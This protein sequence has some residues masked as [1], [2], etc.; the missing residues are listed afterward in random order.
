MKPRFCWHLAY[1]GSLPAHRVP[2][3]HSAITPDPGGCGPLSAPPSSVHGGIQCEKTN[4][5]SAVC[6]RN[7]G[8]SLAVV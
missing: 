3:L 1:Y 5:F 7:A 6:M 8:I 2:Y 4:R